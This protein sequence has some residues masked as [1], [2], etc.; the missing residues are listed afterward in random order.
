VA[1]STH[2]PFLDRDV[3]HVSVSKI[4]Y[5]NTTQIQE[6]DHAMLIHGV[7]G[8]VAVLITY[9]IWLELQDLMQKQMRPILDSMRVVV[10]DGD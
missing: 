1:A 2:V 3:E 10:A 7:K 9:P 6:L 5:L 8:P 4:R